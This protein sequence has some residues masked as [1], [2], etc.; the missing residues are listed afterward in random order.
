MKNK[1]ILSRARKLTYFISVLVLATCF[2]ASPRKTEASFL[3]DVWDS[4]VKVVNFSDRAT[5]SNSSSDTLSSNNAAAVISSI[6]SVDITRAKQLSDEIFS[7]N[8]DPLRKQVLANL[9]IERQM[10]VKEL[11]RKDPAMFLS[12]AIKTDQRNLLPLDI[13]PY[14]EKEATLTSKIEVMHIDDFDNP[15]NSRFDYFLKD[16]D[17]KTR[18]NF[19][20]TD[21]L[22]LVSGTLIKTSGFRLGDNFVSPINKRSFE[23]QETPALESI[24]DQKT[25]VILLD[26]T[27]SGAHPFTKEKAYDLVFNDQFQ[28]FYKEQSYNQVSFSGDVVDWYK[29]NKNR[30]NCSENGDVITDIELGQI[31]K[32]KG[33]DLAKYKRIVLLSNVQNS[34]GWSGIGLWDKEI[35]GISYSF[36]VAC[37]GVGDF[38]DTNEFDWY[39]SATSSGYPFEWKDFDY[40]MSHEMGHSLGLN[41]ANGWVCGNEAIGDNCTDLE[42]GNPF[43]VMGT[44]RKSLHSNAFYKEL[45]GWIKSSQILEINESGTYSINTLEKDSAIKFAK[46]SNYAQ[47]YT[48]YYLEYRKAFGFDSKLKQPYISSNQNGLFINK[49]KENWQGVVDK[50]MLIDASPTEELWYQDIAKTTLN[51]GATFADP[52][53][54]ITIDN[55]SNITADSISFKV[56]YNK[57]P[58]VDLTLSKES[59]GNDVV[60]LYAWR[61]G[62]N[63]Y[64]EMVDSDWVNGEIKTLRND[65]SY[66]LSAVPESEFFYGWNGCDSQTKGKC[67]TDADG[68]EYCSTTSSSENACYVTLSDES[69]QIEAYFTNTSSSVEISASPSSV[70]SGKSAT[71]T[72]TAAGAPLGNCYLYSPTDNLKTIK[73]DAYYLDTNSASRFYKGAGYYASVGRN[74]SGAT[75]NL[76]APTYYTLTCDIDTLNNAVSAQLKVGIATSEGGGSISSVSYPDYSSGI[77]TVFNYTGGVQQYLVPSGI[78]NVEIKASGAQGQGLG[79]ESSAIV[80][81]TPGETLYIHAG[82]QSSGKTGGWNGGSNGG[83]TSWGAYGGGGGGASD[84]RRGGT[85]LANRIIVAGGGGGRGSNDAGGSRMGGNGGNGGSATGGN[86]GSGA[87][88]APVSGGGG[89]GAQASG[90]LAGMAGGGNGGATGNVGNSGN[91]GAGA[92]GPSGASGGG[93]GGGGYY[94]GGGGGS[95]YQSAGGGGGG[96]GYVTGARTSM[97]SGV[98]SGE[99]QVTITYIKPSSSSSSSSVSANHTATTGLATKIAS[100]TATLNGEVNPKGESVYY[101]F[102]YR[103][104]SESS[105]ATKKTSYIFAG[106]GT[107]T[108]SVNAGITDLSSGTKYVYRLYAYSYATQKTVNGELKSFT[109]ATSSSSSSSTATSSVSS[110]SSS[111]SQSSA[112]SSVSNLSNGLISYWKLDEISGTTAFDSTGSNTGTLTGATWTTAKINNGLSF[113]GTSNY[114]NVANNSTLT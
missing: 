43:D 82:G 110:I 17:G 13:Q 20:P 16:I 76:T 1:N 83:S 55:V 79:G 93:G 11:M 24:G 12:L 27:N 108:V 102:F 98:R 32:G 81:V 106:N 10:L 28:D 92:T 31:V 14:I 64:G 53:N 26:F 25:L 87:N 2:I 50:S 42:Y 97:K 107:S 48:P 69:K 34:G 114:L 40:I 72:W 73:S 78:T 70:I 21:S 90:G 44:G 65:W 89:G 75:A 105:E 15:E 36:S 111:S 103:K 19:Y 94:G 77:S 33:I 74:A 45:L 5:P 62:F 56:T 30:S 104:E 99:G 63:D 113:N 60:K 61:D 59:D 18:I 4:I 95:N 7:A 100:T 8:A 49:T 6:T 101:Q 67:W 3:G 22:N 109:T 9:A 96:S 57:S 46:I 41:H 91:G 52:D 71:L 29:L 68:K 112:A 66:K 35:N 51:S 80:T 85:A 39:D 58:S 88:D 54:G 37:V 84:I 86:G 38:F 23:V 47:K